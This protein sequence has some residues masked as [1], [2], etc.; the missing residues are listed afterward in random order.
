[1]QKIIVVGIV[2]RS[3]SEPSRTKNILASIPFDC[4]RHAV[5]KNSIDVFGRGRLA[6]EGY[7]DCIDALAS[8]WRDFRHGIDS[9][10]RRAIEFYRVLRSEYGLRRER[11]KQGNKKRRL[12]HDDS[13][14]IEPFEE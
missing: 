1:M 6:N 3:L 2:T 4:C 8:D 7:V 11:G 14:R 13:F 5:A 9:L 10:S 12:V